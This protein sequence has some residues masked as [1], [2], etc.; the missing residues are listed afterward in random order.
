MASQLKDDLR[1]ILV[2]AKAWLV[3]FNPS[4]SESLIFFSCVRKKTTKSYYPSIF[5]D[6]TQIEEVTSHKHLGVV[7][8]N[9]CS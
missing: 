2:W 7:L 1:K 4:K 3:T 6:Q 8:S 9:D 5:M